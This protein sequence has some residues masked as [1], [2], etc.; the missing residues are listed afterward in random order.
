MNPVRAAS[1]TR[2][3]RPVWSA[4][5]SRRGVYPYLL[6]APVLVLV[7]VGVFYPIIHMVALSLESYITVRPNETH[8]VGLQNYGRLFGDAEFWRSLR[9]SVTWVVGSV[10]PHV[11]PERHV[12]SLDCSEPPASVTEIGTETDPAVGAT[13]IN[14][15]VVTGAAS[16]HPSR[17]LRHEVSPPSSPI[18]T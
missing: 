1:D 17:Q 4:A 5:R 2:V 7:G 14:P 9:V 18:A 6:L 15:R 8:F 13:A 10:V 12:V 3:S 11:P 16:E